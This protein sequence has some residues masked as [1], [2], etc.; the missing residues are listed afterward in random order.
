MAKHKLYSRSA[1]FIRLPTGIGQSYRSVVRKIQKRPI[2]SFLVV[3]VL[4]LLAIITSKTIF[5]PIALPEQKS[6]PLKEVTIYQVGSSPK[7][8]FTGQIR[9]AGVIKIQ[10]QTPGVVTNIAVSEG[11]PV[12]K[13]ENLITI[14]TNYQGANAAGIQAAIATRQYQ[15]ITDTFATQQDLITKQRNLADLMHDNA[16]NLATISAQSIS[17]TQSLINTNQD[18]LNTLSNNLASYQST[19]S[20]G[21]NDTLILQTKM[22]ISQ[23][24]SGQNQLQSALNNLNY[25]TNTS[26]A[27]QQLT[28]LQ[29]DITQKSFDVQEKSLEM[30]R[31]ITKLQLT[32]ANI[33][34][35]FFHPTSPVTGTVERIFVKPLDVVNPGTPLLVLVG[36]SKDL[37]L[38]VQL[39]ESVARQISE[40]DTAAIH[41]P[42]K[43]EELV[44]SYIST[45][46]TDQK[47]FTIT[48][49]LPE[50]DY[51][52]VSDGDFV[53][54]DLPL[55]GQTTVG[56]YFIPLDAVTQTQDQ[57]LV[58]V[59]NKDSKATARPVVLGPVQGQFVAVTGGLNG[60]EKIILDRNVLEGDLVKTL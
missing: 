24:Q 47:L 6:I 51:A 29:R 37:Q 17:S 1:G 2:A 16:S 27:P 33:A 43:T 9:K 19:D 5:T 34:A 4:L 35:S 57:T 55:T 41:F 45:E 46:A 60:S 7:L 58:Y 11:Q 18:I 54:V 42:N 50:G 48:F 28:D 26:N 44:P 12:S 59:I 13:G 40:I 25:S 52:D 21:V 32:L 49:N 30:N 15:Q 38:I 10:S 14:S 22:S 56:N 53:Q 23:F 31:D 39:P 20:A 36:A 3:L 8:S